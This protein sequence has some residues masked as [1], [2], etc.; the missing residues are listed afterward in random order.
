MLPMPEPSAR[1]RRRLDGDCVGIGTSL[2][3]YMRIDV[4]RFAEE[5]GMDL[6]NPEERELL[7]SQSLLFLA[8][9]RILLDL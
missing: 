6:S 2:V 4:I 5:R 8:L 3:Y 9:I 1:R 7:R